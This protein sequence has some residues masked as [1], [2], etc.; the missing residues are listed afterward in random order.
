M[1]HALIL[2]HC[3]GGNLVLHSMDTGNISTLSSTC[4]I[5][6]SNISWNIELRDT[7]IIFNGRNVNAHCCA[8]TAKYCTS[9]K[10]ATPLFIIVHVQKLWTLNL[11]LLGRYLKQNEFFTYCNNLVG[12][13][14]NQ[15]IHFE[16]PCIWYCWWVKGMQMKV[17]MELATLWTG[18]EFWNC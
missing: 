1:L 8:T 10:H 11:G 14:I 16:W 15:V 13:S 9:P 17:G 5:R 3:G 2:L 7:W 18:S 6:S 4:G 12:K